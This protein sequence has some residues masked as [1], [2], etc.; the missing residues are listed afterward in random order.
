[1]AGRQGFYSLQRKLWL[2]L[3]LTAPRP[4]LGPI[5]PPIQWVP[6]ALFL[7]VKRPERGADQLSGAHI[8]NAWSYASIPHTSSWLALKH[9]DNFTFTL[10]LLCFIHL[11]SLGPSTCSF[12]FPVVIYSSYGILNLLKSSHGRPYVTHDHTTVFLI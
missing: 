5:Q 12:F 9:R 3:F 1:V 10:S 8:N 2:F 4:A 7:G 6:E 11:P